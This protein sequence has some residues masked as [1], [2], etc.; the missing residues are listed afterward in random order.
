MVIF[1]MLSCFNSFFCFQLVSINYLIL[2]LKYYIVSNQSVAKL[3]GCGSSLWL[4][5]FSTINLSAYI[6][7]YFMFRVCVW[8]YCEKNTTSFSSIDQLLKLGRI[9]LW[10]G[11]KAMPTKFDFIFK[12]L[13]VSRDLSLLIAFLCLCLGWSSVFSLNNQVYNKILLLLLIFKISMI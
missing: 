4:L 11:T 5:F 9:L 2:E 6:K 1:G 10:F 7:E 8:V 3:F 13:F 12:V